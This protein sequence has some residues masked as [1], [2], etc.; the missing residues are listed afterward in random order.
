MSDL[1]AAIRRV[2]LLANAA[3]VTTERLAGL[4]NI[5]HLVTVGDA[6]YVLRIRA[7]ARRSTSTES[8]RRSRLARRRRPASTPTSC[9]S[10]RPTG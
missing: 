3:G 5:N 2:P 10:I 1:D 8:T 4:T 9:S 7:R 6:R